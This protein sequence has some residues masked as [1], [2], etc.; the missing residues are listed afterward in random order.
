MRFIKIE[1]QKFYFGVIAVFL[2]LIVFINGCNSN[3]KIE[4]IPSINCKNMDLYSKFF[5]ISNGNI[6]V[7]HNYFDLQKNNWINAAN[8]SFGYLGN[9]KI[10]YNITCT[11]LDF[12]KCKVFLE[13]RFKTTHKLDC[14]DLKNSYLCKEERI[15]FAPGKNEPGTYS[16]YFTFDNQDFLLVIQIKDNKPVIKNTICAIPGLI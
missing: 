12:D 15:M 13:G 5:T 10:V 14:T 2:A 11:E 1:N 9:I 16:P 8:N 4:P 3:K 6:L 7:D